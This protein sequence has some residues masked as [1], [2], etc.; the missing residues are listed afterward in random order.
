MVL[1]MLAGFGVAY[2]NGAE[3]LSLSLGMAGVGGAPDSVGA[4]GAGYLSVRL[5]NA[6]YMDVGGRLGL[7]AG[8]F[9]EVT[10]INVAGRARFGEHVFGR[11]GLV[12]QHET[13]WADYV[14]SP[15]SHTIGSGDGIGHRSG[16]D[17]GLGW[18]WT[19]PAVS[20]SAAHVSVAA[21]G[22][23][24]PDD[25]GPH[26]YGILETLLTIDLGKPADD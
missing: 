13:P 7:L 5:T 21:I 4:L 9:R 3:R 10:G 8:P 17:A 6:L 2:A 14:A 19:L 15:I 1:G 26:L 25:H 22:S 18:Q 20:T 16:L 12:H 11:F 24:F 23:W